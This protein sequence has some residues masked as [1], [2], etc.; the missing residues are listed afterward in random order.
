M[1][2]VKMIFRDACN[3]SIVSK[4]EANGVKPLKS[5]DGAAVRRPFTEKE[6]RRAYFRRWRWRAMILASFYA[7]GQRLGDVVRLA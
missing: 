2:I 5:S 3:A 1:K 6:L 4:S 7:G